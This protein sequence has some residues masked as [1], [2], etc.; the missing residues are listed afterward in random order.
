[1][2]RLPFRIPVACLALLGTGCGPLFFL[3]AETQETCTTE[4]GLTF[5]AA[6]PTTVSVKQTVV[7]P[8]EDIADALPDGDTE[9]TLRLKRFELTPT[10]G[11]PDLRGIERA[12]VS[13]RKPGQTG[14]TP[15]LEYRRPST[16]TAPPKIAAT[17]TE[18]VDLAEQIREQE[19]ELVFE[20]R[21]SLPAQE[22]KAD[23]RACAGLQVKVDYLDWV[24]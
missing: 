14:L 19:L 12:L 18:S 7:F 5:P 3:E 6:L 22:W 16:Q 8:L 2:R 9:A 13:L 17:G 4:R 10:Q 1:M 21:G 15:L 23:F 24:F 11:N 20:A